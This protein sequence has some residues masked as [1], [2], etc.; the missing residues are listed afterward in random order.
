LLLLLLLLLFLVE[1]LAFRR[2]KWKGASTKAE[3][4]VR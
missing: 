4:C 2:C 1:G 3:V